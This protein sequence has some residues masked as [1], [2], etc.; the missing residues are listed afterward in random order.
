MDIPPVTELDYAV[1]RVNGRISQKDVLAAYT[2][3]PTH[4]LLHYRLNEDDWSCIEYNGRKVYRIRESLAN[5]VWE[6]HIINVKMTCIA[7]QAYN[8]LLSNT[9]VCYYIPN[10]KFEELGM[11]NAPFG[12]YKD[13]ITNPLTTTGSR[14][15]VSDWFDTYQRNGLKLEAWMEKAKIRSVRIGQDCSWSWPDEPFPPLPYALR[16]NW[17][18]ESQVDAEYWTF[19]DMW[20]LRPLKTFTR[21][22]GHLAIMN[23]ALRRVFKILNGSADD[24]TIHNTADDNV[25]HDHHPSSSSTSTHGPEC[26]CNFS[27]ISNTATA[28]SSILDREEEMQEIN[29]V[30]SNRR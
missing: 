30:S 15:F 25:I 23:R 28:S 21:S 8:P 5:A 4:K 17:S 11:T 14:S 6:Y 27:P 20:G 7:S 3:Y 1:E 9:A 19:E 29:Y 13:L 18:L 2:L 24:D 26:M 16:E 22:G 10:E 12:N